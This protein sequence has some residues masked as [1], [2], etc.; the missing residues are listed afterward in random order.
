[1]FVTKSVCLPWCLWVYEVRVIKTHPV[2]V[3]LGW[4]LSK[5]C[6][7]AGC[8]CNANVLIY[9]PQDEPYVHVI[10]QPLWRKASDFKLLLTSTTA[11]RSQQFP[12]LKR[13]TN[14]FCFLNS[15][16]SVGASTE[17][18]DMTCWGETY[19]TATEDHVVGCF[20][21]VKLCCSSVSVQT[22]LWFSESLRAN[23][24]QLV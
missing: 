3:P 12:L 18:A 4:K 16:V 20:S 21:S 14:F 10:A 9:N 7:A 5:C 15:P 2:I 19:L 13:E 1:M 24:A 6:R 23:R 17:G 8:S 11:S 22:S